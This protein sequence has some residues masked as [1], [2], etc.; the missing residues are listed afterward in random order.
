MNSGFFLANLT[1]RQMC[2]LAIP[3][4]PG[5]LCGLEPSKSTWW[6]V[7]GNPLMSTLARAPKQG[8]G[9]HNNS[10][11]SWG[12]LK[13]PAH[14]LVASGGGAWRL[15]DLRAGA[16][17]ATVVVVEVLLAEGLLKMDDREGCALGSQ[18]TLWWQRRL[19]R[20]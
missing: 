1:V 8:R 19:G 13:W 2:A 4:Q 9:L 20:L 17:M 11:R 5:S 6:R 3:L 15:G 10:H 16:A 18:L 12:C 14:S 7:P